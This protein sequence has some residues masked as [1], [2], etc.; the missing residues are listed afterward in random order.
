MRRDG[1]PE[2]KFRMDLITKMKEC[3]V[4]GY[5]LIM[6]LDSNVDMDN[7]KLTQAIELEPKLKMKDL[8]RERVRKDG[9]AP[10]FR[11]TKQ[12]YGTFETPYLDFYGARFLTV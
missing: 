3:I 9:P 12:I 10:W 5:R 1:V 8:V 4:Q 2:E 6:M 7:G 11:V